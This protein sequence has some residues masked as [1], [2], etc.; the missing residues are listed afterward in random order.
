MC[1]GAGLQTGETALMT[2]ME[3][4]HTEVAITI[5]VSD[6]H[7]A[8][9]LTARCAQLRVSTSARTTAHEWACLHGMMSGHDVWKFGARCCVVLHAFSRT[10]GGACRLRGSRCAHV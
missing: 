10:D 3:E 5:R 8:T 9:P 6:Q 4:G 7:L 1:G 2:A